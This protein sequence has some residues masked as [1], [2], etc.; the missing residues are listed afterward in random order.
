MNSSCVLSHYIEISEK[1]KDI[2]EKSSS[3]IDFDADNGYHT[4]G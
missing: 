3:R 1:L 4:E 2:W